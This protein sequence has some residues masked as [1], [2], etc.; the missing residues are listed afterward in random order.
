[1]SCHEL[2]SVTKRAISGT[3]GSRAHLGATATDG[4]PGTVTGRPVLAVAA[5]SA[6][7]PP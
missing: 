2:S 3:A 6:A 5:G 4:E 1:M 7:A